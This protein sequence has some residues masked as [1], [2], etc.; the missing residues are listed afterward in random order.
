MVTVK[1]RRKV[2][3][4][5]VGLVQG[6]GLVVNSDAEAS[7]IEGIDWVAVAYFDKQINRKRW[8]VILI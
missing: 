5:F 6:I 1:I 7:I 4:F 8:W 3:G 2:A